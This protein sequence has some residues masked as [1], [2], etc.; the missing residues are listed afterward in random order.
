M[1]PPS[2][3][4]FLP[5][6]QLNLV[7]ILRSIQK[8]T[9]LHTN[10]RDILK[11]QNRGI[12]WG[13]LSLGHLLPLRRCH[14]QHLWHRRSSFI[15]IQFIFQRLTLLGQVNALDGEDLETW[16]PS[17]LEEVSLKWDIKNAKQAV[18]A[19]WKHWSLHRTAH[20]LSVLWAPKIQQ[21]LLV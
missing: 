1:R 13:F 9:M 8:H 5:F 20:F 3:F 16:S 4:G 2:G 21:K 19:L 18:E 17:S 6:L 11:M 7:L 10:V 15:S 12:I 14:F